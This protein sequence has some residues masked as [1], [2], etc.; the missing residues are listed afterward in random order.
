MKS[1]FAKLYQR[2]QPTRDFA[3]MAR[4]AG[5]LGR[6]F[7]AKAFLTVATAVH[8]E[9]DDLR[10]DLAELK[11]R[12]ETAARTG[13]TLADALDAETRIQVSESALRPDGKRPLTD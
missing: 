6:G 13:R 7:Q 1:R 11:R 9:R 10:R 4:L 8:P 2:N 12:D 5:Q 3:E